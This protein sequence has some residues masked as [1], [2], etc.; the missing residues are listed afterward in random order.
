MEIK[1]QALFPSLIW[2]TLFDDFEQF[3]P[4]LLQHALALRERD[5]AG[6]QKSNQAGWQSDNTLQT[7]PEFEPINTRIIQACQRIAHSQH[8]KPQL[9]FHHQAWANI[10]PP[11]ASNQVHYHAN[12]H[13]SGVYYLSLDAPR[14]GNIFFRDPRVASRMLTYPVAQQ[15]SFTAT[16]VRMPAEVGRLY[17]FPGWLEHGVDT[18]NSDADRV[19]ISFNVLASP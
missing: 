19:S 14:C 6:V 12:C 13:F 18:N 8:F 7:L 3:N 10:S 4:P 16:E 15:N 17:I 1:T 2:S 9:N 5:P 11:G